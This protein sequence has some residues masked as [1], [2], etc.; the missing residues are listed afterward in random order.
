MDNEM[1]E[2]LLFR[3]IFHNGKV[4]LTDLFADLILDSQL[5]WFGNYWFTISNICTPHIDF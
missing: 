5:R 1:Y 4:S 2:Y 3:A